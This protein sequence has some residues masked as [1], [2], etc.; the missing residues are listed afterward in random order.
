[1][2]RGE[3]ARRERRAA[4]E[5]RALRLTR[6]SALVAAAATAAIA[7]VWLVSEVRG[8]RESTTTIAR[9][10]IAVHVDVEGTMSAVRTHLMTPPP[11]GGRWEYKISS[12]APDGA[13][14]EEGA[15]VVVFDTSELERMLLEMRAA[16]DTAE[17]EIEKKR[18]SIDLRRREDDLKLAEARAKLDKA[19]LKLER[20]EEFVAAKE[21][22]LLELDKVLAEKEVAFL[23]SQRK[24]VDEADEVELGI[25]GE[26]REAAALEVR[27]IE[28][29]IERM[30]RRAPR[31]GT[32]IHVTDR[33]GEKK[34]VGDT[35]WRRERILE[36]PDLTEMMARG[37]VDEADAGRVAVG[38]RVELR[39]D[40]YPDVDFAGTIE[41]IGQ[42]VQP[43]TRNS[44]LRVVRVDIALDQTD[45]TRMRPEMR[46]RGRIEVERRADVL[47]APLG[48]V[49]YTPAGATVRRRSFSGY[50]EVPVELGARN[51]EVVEV[52]ES[53]GRLAA[54]DE[55]WTRP[56]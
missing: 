41:K 32:V 17:K 48:A 14:V 39:L 26:Q 27:K 54:G 3:R 24:L 36:I 31:D 2:R 9:G 51:H 38:Q 34:R 33:R 7:A 11:L 1:M 10:D 56:Q 52:V 21:L 4:G 40:A 53:H 50:E 44:P 42:T 20:P 35:V 43:K 30:T 45:P 46:F 37:I 29:G 47:S 28:T 5:G 16:L 49:L 15:V 18:T 55:V 8:S 22:A 23:E 19:G 25:L 13:D 6:K 12:M